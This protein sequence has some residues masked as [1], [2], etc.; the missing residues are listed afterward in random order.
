MCIILY[1]S[2]E[3]PGIRK[4]KRFQH[5]QLFFIIDYMSLLVLLHDLKARG[6]FQEA[7][8]T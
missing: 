5:Y 6:L 2:C 4:Q 8:L 3:F 1:Y 7:L